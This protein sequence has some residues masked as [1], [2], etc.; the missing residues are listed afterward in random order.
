MFKR[1]KLGIFAL[2]IIATAASCSQYQQAAWAAMT[3]QERENYVAYTEGRQ[4]VNVSGSSGDCFEAIDRHWPAGSREWARSIVRRES[5]NTPTAKNPRSTASGCFQLLQMHAH[6]IP[7]GWGNR[8]DADANTL[9]A[10]HLY[11]QAGT[12]PWNL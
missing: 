12:S 2:V 9:G 5:G 7:G 3:G 8:F 6:R 11:N 1:I 4:P 10:L